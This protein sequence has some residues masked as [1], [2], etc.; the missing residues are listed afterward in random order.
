ML[1]RLLEISHEEVAR[2]ETNS[3]RLGYIT[4]ILE[5]LKARDL[6]R[7]DGRVP[8]AGCP[9]V[10]AWLSKCFILNASFA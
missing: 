3:N 2:A 9:A 4:E 7:I 6:E 8:R 1:F 10:L 5:L